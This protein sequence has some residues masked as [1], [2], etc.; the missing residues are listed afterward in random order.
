MRLGQARGDYIE[1]TRG[2]EPG[3]TV[4]SS[5][6]FKLRAGATVIVDNDLAPDVSLDPL[7]PES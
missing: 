2:L 5:G 7:P 6:V 1:V 3:E 4:A